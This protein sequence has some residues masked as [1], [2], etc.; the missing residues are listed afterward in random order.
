MSQT[1]ID[2]LDALEGQIAALSAAV[3]TADPTKIGQKAEDGARHG[4]SSALSG[5]PQAARELQAVAS[6]L[7]QYA[8]PA[9]RMAQE[10]QQRRRWWKPAL[11]GLIALLMLLSGFTGGVVAVRSG[12]TMSTEVGCRFLGGQWGQ[13]QEGEFVCWRSV[14]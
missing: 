11:I 14:K 7:R 4:A 12:L 2:A 5:L 6:D 10:A 1:L 13:R 3:K 8:L 9:A